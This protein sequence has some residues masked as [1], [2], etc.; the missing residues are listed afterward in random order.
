M[1]YK[2]LSTEYYLS[3]GKIPKECLYS[4]KISRDGG[5]YQIYVTSNGCHINSS[6]EVPMSEWIY[7]NSKTANTNILTTSFFVLQEFTH[8]Q[9]ERCQ[10]IGRS[11]HA[12]ISNMGEKIEMQNI[13]TTRIIISKIMNAIHSFL[14]KF[15]P[16]IER[17]SFINND[18]LRFHNTYPLKMSLPIISF[19]RL[20]NKKI[21]IKREFKKMKI[22]NTK[23]LNEF[24][25]SFKQLSKQIL[26]GISNF[27]NVNRGTNNV[28]TMCS[29]QTKKI[30]SVDFEQ[31]YCD[32]EITKLITN[33]DKREKLVEQM[34]CEMT[35][36]ARESTNMKKKTM[37]I[38]AHADEVRTQKEKIQETMRKKMDT[39]IKNLRESYEEKN[40]LSLSKYLETYSFD[41][42]SLFKIMR[43]IKKT[44]VV[45]NSIYSFQIHISRTVAL[46][47][48][49]NGSDNFIPHFYTF[50][51]KIIKPYV[52]TSNRLELKILKT[53]WD[54]TFG[55]IK[56]CGDSHEVL[57]RKIDIIYWSMTMRM[58]ENR[59]EF[60]NFMPPF[61]FAFF[62]LCSNVQT[63]FEIVAYF[64][65]YQNFILSN[66]GK[67][68][69]SKIKIAFLKLFLH[70]PY[71]YLLK[72]HQ[73]L[74]SSRDCTI[75][76]IFEKPA[77]LSNCPIKF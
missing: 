37:K 28:T 13:T 56:R 19:A 45:M 5:F 39:K 3:F 34:K 75:R 60:T 11:K 65:K 50:W 1:L 71:F 42:E 36:L 4:H 2:F 33:D 74:L 29:T 23:Q 21:V 57:D 69:Y 49:Q 41:S 18:V 9:I 10:E 48:Y 26:N 62:R 31:N 8:I 64:S 52:D 38:M 35:N 22:R 12:G 59:I 46:A 25:E 43:G 15:S 51:T 6:G 30:E 7:S 44:H 61:F 40:Q 54:E 47:D 73:T 66:D 58:N 55:A 70:E 76:N 20:I 63:A 67:E 77:F 68:L 32:P 72:R 27:Q 17:A 14:Q 53:Y 16:T 24:K